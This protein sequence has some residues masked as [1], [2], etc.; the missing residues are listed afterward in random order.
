[1]GSLALESKRIYREVVK[2]LPDVPEEAKDILIA[3][4]LSEHYE[5]LAIPIIKTIIKET[6]IEKR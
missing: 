6:H 3:R 2:L 4:L 5:H 1:M